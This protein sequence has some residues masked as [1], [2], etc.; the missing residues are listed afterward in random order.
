MAKT[1]KSFRELREEREEVNFQEEIKI[2]AAVDR[3]FKKYGVPNAKLDA[4]YIFAEVLQVNRNMLK[5]YLHRE[6]A[7]KEK[8]NLREN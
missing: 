7:E 3:L 4:E 5:L 6:I 2:I 1:Q 8:Q